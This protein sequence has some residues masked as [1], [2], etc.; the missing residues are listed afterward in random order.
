MG[1]D[2]VDVGDGS[3]Y[4]CHDM[5]SEDDECVAYT[6]C[7]CV[8]ATA[9]EKS[10]GDGNGKAPRMECSRVKE[11]RKYN[12]IKSDEDLMSE[13]LLSLDGPEE[14]RLLTSLGTGRGGMSAFD[15]EEK[16]LFIRCLTE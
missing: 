13:M 11:K 3:S 7:V 14:E 10:V 16:A 12:G 9:M 1:A 5:E 4:G 15:E 2:L 8:K 6:D